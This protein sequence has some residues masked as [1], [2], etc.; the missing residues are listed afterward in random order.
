[1]SEKSHDVVGYNNTTSYR[2]QPIPYPRDRLN[3]NF[4]YVKPTPR[5]EPTWWHQRAV[6]TS[7]DLQFLLARTELKF[8]V[9]QP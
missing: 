9:A 1:M 5:Y 3:N 2:F 4:V 7:D 6:S 8:T